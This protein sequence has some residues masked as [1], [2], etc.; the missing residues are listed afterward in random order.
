MG[1]VRKIIFS[2]EYHKRDSEA[3]NSLNNAD[4]RGRSFSARGPGSSK[5]GH[6]LGALFLGGMMVLGGKVLAKPKAANSNELH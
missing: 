5:V 1:G 2:K 4:I 6:V 3:L